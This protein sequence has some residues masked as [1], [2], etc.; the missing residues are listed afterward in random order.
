M[1]NKNIR[2]LIV[3]D[4]AL[5]ALYIKMGLEQEGFTV[6]NCLATGEEAIK[7]IETEP[8]DLILMDV[9]LAGEMDGITAAGIILKRISRCQIIFMTGYSHNDITE[10]LNRHH[11]KPLAFLN[12]PIEVDA[13]K[14]LIYEN[15][16]I[17]M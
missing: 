17:P 6:F 7:Q 11:I 10:R 15:Y 5:I 4:E 14:K 2:I 3:E 8:C 13:V 16:E 1:M 12:K 9:N